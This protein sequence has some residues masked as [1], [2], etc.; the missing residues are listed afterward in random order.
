MEEN[1]NVTFWFR[2]FKKWKVAKLQNK[3][4]QMHPMD[5][6]RL[7]ERSLKDYLL[8]DIIKEREKAL[9]IY[10]LSD[11]SLKEELN[12]ISMELQNKRIEIKVV[13]VDNTMT[14]KDTEWTRIIVEGVEMLL[15]GF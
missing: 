2:H 6:K 8:F 12:N 13:P 10:M 14:Q 4:S 9:S 1:N 15:T 11:D 5:I 3:L 7:F